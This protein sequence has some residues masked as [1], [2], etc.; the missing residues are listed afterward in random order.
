MQRELCP[1]DLS[2]ALYRKERKDKG[3]RHKASTHGGKRILQYNLAGQLENEYESLADAVDNNGIGATYQGILFCCQG[4]IRKH[5]S[6]I[7]R[8]DSEDD[9]SEDISNLI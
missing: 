1:E 4:R 6:K 8:F 7:W 3:K 5:C 9:K 2:E